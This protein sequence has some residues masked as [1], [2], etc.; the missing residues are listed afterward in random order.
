MGTVINLHSAAYRAHINN[1]LNVYRAGGPMCIVEFY[2]CRALGVANKAK[3]ARG[4]AA[5]LSL[6]SRA[7][8]INKAR[9]RAAMTAGKAL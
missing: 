3:H 6:L 7:R 8:T 9:Q 1:A 5:C 2:L 4:Q